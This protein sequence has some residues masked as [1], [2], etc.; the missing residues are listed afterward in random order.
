LLL[1]LTHAQPD[2][3][4]I[5][6]SLECLSNS[7]V[8]NVSQGANSPQ[9]F[10]VSNAILF[11]KQLMGHGVLSRHYLLRNQKWGPWPASRSLVIGPMST[12]KIHFTCTSDVVVMT[13]FPLRWSVNNFVHSLDYAAGLIGL[14]N[15][16]V[17]LLLLNRYPRV[18]RLVIRLWRWLGIKVI[19]EEPDVALL[20]ST[21]YVMPWS[22]IPS[23]SKQMFAS[24]NASLYN[25]MRLKLLQNDR[26]L[27]LPCKCS[28]LLINRVTSRKIKN[29][30]QVMEHISNLPC[31]AKVASMEDMSFDDQ[32][33][34]AMDSTTIVA[35]HGAA[36]FAW[37][38]VLPSQHGFVII[39]SSGFAN[40]TENHHKGVANR[41]PSALLRNNGTTCLACHAKR[42][43]DVTIDTSKLLLAIS[44]VDPFLSHGQAKKGW[45]FVDNQ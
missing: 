44:A 45:Q 17:T 18:D 26:L 40:T 31:A 6:K 38:K 14:A 9:Y 33:S 35:V 41:H 21:S 12:T 4:C 11:H 43:G 34:T 36:I 32:A 27:N 25:T 24:Y 39:S 29:L 42:G 3:N 22:S 37:S 7:K 16:P 19:M 28:I 20:S 30:V 23:F 15:K 10:K 13:V 1:F 8:V 2:T 5:I